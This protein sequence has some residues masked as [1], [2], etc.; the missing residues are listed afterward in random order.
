MSKH[1][2]SFDI[3]HEILSGNLGSVQYFSMTNPWIDFIILVEAD[4][5]NMSARVVDKCMDEY[6]DSDDLCYGDIVEGALDSLRLPY[7]I[8]YHDA[9]ETDGI[10]ESLWENILDSIRKYSTKFVGLY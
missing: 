5:V 9:D 8:I 4:N 1:S 2:I 10:Y 6:W 3:P 7:T